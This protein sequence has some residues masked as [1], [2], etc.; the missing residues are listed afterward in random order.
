MKIT[1]R[2]IA[3][4]AGTLALLGLGGVGLAWAQTSPSTTTPSTTTAPSASSDT[5]GC[6]HD[7]TPGSTGNTDTT[8]APTADQTSV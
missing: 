7:G 3:T 6:D 8:Q 5:K 1:S 2:I 4:L